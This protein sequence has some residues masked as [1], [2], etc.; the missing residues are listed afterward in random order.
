MSVYAA[1]PE[2]RSVLSIREARSDALPTCASFQEAALG[3]GQVICGDT[4]PSARQQRAEMVDEKGCRW[5][6]DGCNIKRYSPDEACRVLIEGGLDRILLV[7]DSFMRH[8]HISFLTLLFGQENVEANPFI[9]ERASGV[10][11]NDLP[12]G[13]EPPRIHTCPLD[14]TLHSGNLP[15]RHAYAR[16]TWLHLDAPRRHLL[17]KGKFNLEYVPSPCCHCLYMRQKLFVP[18]HEKQDKMCSMKDGKQQ[19]ALTDCE[20]RPCGRNGSG[21]DAMFDGPSRLHDP[22]WIV[23]DMHANTTASLVVLG[24][25]LEHNFVAT[26]GAAM[27]AAALKGIAQSFPRPPWLMWHAADA[28]VRQDFVWQTRERALAFNH[29]MEGVLRRPHTVPT[30]LRHTGQSIIPIARFDNVTR[31]LASRDGTH[32]GQGPNLMKAHL[33]I[34]RIEDMLHI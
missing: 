5:Q 4:R 17:C 33:L 11:N 3:A 16:D 12:M 22:N 21:T 34:R 23:G 20:M 7:G 8:L 24:W 2:L 18:T 6:P 19:W 1:T 10:P 27:L 15:C 31:S 28:R 26:E 25:G 30:A 32:W 14:L 9:V 29:E 13:V